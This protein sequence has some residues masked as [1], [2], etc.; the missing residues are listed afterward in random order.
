MATP[1]QAGTAPVSPISMDME[2]A[3]TRRS[4]RAKKAPVK[5]E[6]EFVPATYKEPSQPVIKPSRPKRKA[7]EVATQNIDAEETGTLL[8]EI[9]SRMSPDERKEYGGW[10]EL[11]SEPGFFTAM[12]QEL[13]AK[14]LKVQEVYNLDAETLG[15]LSSP[16]HG[17]IFL[18]QYEGD[19]EVSDD[20][21]RKDC[22]N[23]LWF[24][25][26]TTANACATVAL[27]NIVMNAQG[28]GLGSQLQRFKDS[29]ENLPPPHR[30]HFLDANAFIRSI[31]NSVARRIDLVAEDLGLDNKYE[32]SLKKRKARKKP[33]RP[34]RKKR[35]VETT[36]HYIAY[37]P[38][39]GHV[40]EL[41]GF[42]AK[43]LR[44]GPIG[45]SWLGT[46]SKAILDRMHRNSNFSSYSLL[47]ICHSPLKTLSN[48]LAASLACSHAL[49]KLYSGNP[50]W[51]VSD[52]FKTFDDARLAQLNLT[53]E[54]IAGLELPAS[55]TTKTGEIDFGP[56][57]ALELAGKLKAEQDSLDAQHVVELATVDEA[58]EMVRGR[59]RDYTP[60]IHQWVR[61]LAEKGALRE[62]ILEMDLDA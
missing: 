61:A 41:D 36:Y 8:D 3:C 20:D 19:D 5:Y 45:D 1:E 2:D 62:L 51:S 27:M 35:R 15:F 44:I 22:P 4:S 23:H 60:A 47:S 16:V 59:Q 56:A 52:P 28:V 26:Q 32:E 21:N 30:G 6:D 42:Q 58:V 37:V 46:A 9:L 53:R 33:A 43:P 34:T 25:N 10:V 17:L 49:D 29:T 50:T 55:F 54:G 13:G 11:E 14:D 40:W 39:N 24:A 12:L 38:A 48:E 57:E 7:A 31:H 18:F